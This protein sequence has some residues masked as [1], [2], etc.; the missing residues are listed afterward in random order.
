MQA[1]VGIQTEDAIAYMRMNKNKIVVTEIRSYEN[2]WQNESR[3]CSQYR[4]ET[5]TK[6]KCYTLTACFMRK[7]N[8]EKGDGDGDVVGVDSNNNFG[9]TA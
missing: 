4:A 6:P 2:K 1:L 3:L 9:E 5:T 7:Y 8:G